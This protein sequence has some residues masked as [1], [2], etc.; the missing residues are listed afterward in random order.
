MSPHR[1]LRAGLALVLLMA[2]ALAPA[3]AAA[4]TAPA[5]VYGDVNND[6]K[7]TAVDALAILY[8]TVNRALPF[9]HTVMKGDVNLDARVT[10]QDALIILSHTVDRDVSQFPVGKLMPTPVAGATILW[11]GP[12][13]GGSWNDSLNWA[14]RRTPGQGDTAYV[15]PGTTAT[16]AASAS[17]GG[18]LLPAGATLDMGQS[19][20]SASN[21]EIRGTVRGSLPQGNPLRLHGRRSRV[22]GTI[23]RLEGEKVTVVG[24]TTIT[25]DVLVDSLVVSGGSL[26]VGDSL[27]VDSAL[28]MRS[29]ADTVIAQRKA[30]L[31]ADTGAIT[32]GVLRLRGDTLKY[33]QRFI[34]SG[35][36]RTVFERAGR[37]VIVRV[38]PETSLTPEYIALQDVE[39]AGS[40][41]L[42]L[43]G[44]SDLTVKGLLAMTGT[45]R[46]TGA[47]VVARGD[48]R[49]AAG[50]SLLSQ[51]FTMRGGA[52]LDFQGTFSPQDLLLS[53]G[54]F[55]LPGGPN[56]QY[57]YVTGRSV[58][59]AGR[60]N[61]QVRLSVD[62]L[63]MNGKQATIGTLTADSAVVMQSPADTLDV[64]GFATLRAPQGSLTAGVLRLRDNVTSPFFASS[65]NH[66]VVLAGPAGQTFTT[67]YPV[68]M[69]ITNLD[70]ESDSVRFV[71]DGTGA[72]LRVTN[73]RLVRA[74]AMTVPRLFLY[75]KVFTTLA[76]RLHVGRM[77][78]DAASTWENFGTINPG[79]ARFHKPWVQ[80]PAWRYTSL[81]LPKS[82]SFTG[83]TTVEG[84]VTGDTVDVNGQTVTVGGA[85]TGVLRSRNAAGDL[86]V[87][88]LATLNNWNANITAGTLRFAGNVTG[89]VSATGTA[90]VIAAGTTEQAFT[91]SAMQ[92]ANLRVTNP[93]WVQ[94]T[95][96][97][98]FEVA[99]TLEVVG[100]F[101]NHSPLIVGQHLLFRTGSRIFN[102]G[103][104]QYR[105]QYTF[106]PGASYVFGSLPVKI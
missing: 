6:G 51:R 102:G 68:G 14:P 31:R 104:I 19:S 71:L 93:A 81:E 57:R 65:L 79:R 26:T 103:T 7:V 72:Y 76:A 64:T 9:T 20:L 23:S 86:T 43:P 60:V 2:A 83:P 53:G 87:R 5:P 11:V 62:S 55:S 98:G 48:V 74:G 12:A 42:F 36:H 27:R 82:G 63:R 15:P 50:T 4:Q 3:P 21:A 105:N 30:L 8:Y 24:P 58:V 54:R 73:L 77:E 90:Q 69:E 1:T 85:F 45:S 89:S 66:K 13:T 88:G 37:Q 101:S 40:A 99:G 34:T 67:P 17:I 38:S 10:A 59:L 29:A 35:T 16:M 92:L 84:E 39:T 18:L 52:T 47:Y 100:S 22:A 80:V 41:E 33:L 25:H 49:G 46:L 75:G 95:Y 97:N 70:S 106:E 91:G 32:A 28:V 56:Y 78:L 61:V 94:F 44:V 96:P